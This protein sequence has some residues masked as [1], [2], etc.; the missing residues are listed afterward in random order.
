MLQ[1]EKIRRMIESWSLADSTA[2]MSPAAAIEALRERINAGQPKTPLISSSGRSVT[3]L[4]RQHR[5]S[6]G[7]AAGW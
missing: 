3:G 4:H 5:A 6:H 7:H 1:G 2:L